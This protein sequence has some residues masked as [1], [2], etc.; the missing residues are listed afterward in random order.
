MGAL[1]GQK[2]G[3]GSSLTKVRNPSFAIFWCYVLRGVLNFF[4]RSN[5]VI[6]QKH[7]FLSFPPPHFDINKMT[8]LLDSNT[9]YSKMA[10]NKL[11]F[12]LHVN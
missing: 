10:P 2:E 8:G 6:F 7:F 12:C 9:P 1:K 5:R 3:R 11:F 4:K